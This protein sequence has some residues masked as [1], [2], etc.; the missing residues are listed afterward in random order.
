MN[1]LEKLDLL[2]KSRNINKH[3]LSQLSGIPYTTIDG[4]YKKG[5]EGAKLPTV[6]K[7]ADF[8]G[9]TIDYLVRDE[10]EDICYGLQSN[11]NFSEEELKHV[12]IY[13]TLN[14]SGRQKVN[15]Y[16]DLLLE[17]EKF[18]IREILPMPDIDGIKKWAEPI[19]KE[20]RKNQS[21]PVK[22]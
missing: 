5:Y 18:R 14:E 4:W 22:K 12:K 11:S 6:Q 15:E 3:V 16:M 1:F 19:A 9:T 13:R 17:S 7:L 10:I 8:F 20:L 21:S 2:I